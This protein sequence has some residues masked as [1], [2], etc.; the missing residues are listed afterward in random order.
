MSTAR[1]KSE[2]DLIHNSFKAYQVYFVLN[3]EAL[4]AIYVENVIIRK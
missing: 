1:R 2:N 4:I 3:S